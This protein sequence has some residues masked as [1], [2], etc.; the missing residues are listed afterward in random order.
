MVYKAYIVDFGNG[1]LKMV[2]GIRLPLAPE[3]N[4]VCYACSP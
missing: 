1:D 4:V 2:N 3:Y